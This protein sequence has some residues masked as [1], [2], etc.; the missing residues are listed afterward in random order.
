[1]A[2]Q[3]GTMAKTGGEASDARSSVAA[4]YARIASAVT[5]YDRSGPAAPSASR[6]KSAT[7]VTPSFPSS[8][9]RSR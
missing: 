9:R 2:S 3:T 7:A 5:T 1:M 4:A 8:G 6:R